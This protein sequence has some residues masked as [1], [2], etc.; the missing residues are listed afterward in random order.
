MNHSSHMPL[1]N[2][3]ELDLKRGDVYFLK[4]RVY[5]GDIASLKY[6]VS[7]L[8]PLLNAIMYGLNASYTETGISFN[9][10]LHAIPLNFM[11]TMNATYLEEGEWVKDL[12]VKRSDPVPIDASLI[13]SEAFIEC[14]E[15]ENVRAIRHRVDTSSHAVA[16]S[17]RTL[18]FRS[19]MWSIG[20][21][22]G[23][24]VSNEEVRAIVDALRGSN[25]NVA[26]VH[27]H[28][29]CTQF[30]QK[31]AVLT[32]TLKG[33]KV[34]IGGVMIDVTDMRLVTELDSAISKFYKNDGRV[35]TPFGVFGAIK[36]SN[37]AFAQS[38]WGV[39]CALLCGANIKVPKNPF[40]RYAMIAAWNKDYNDPISRWVRSFVSFE[41]PYLM[42]RKIYHAS[43]ADSLPDMRYCVFIDEE[44]VPTV[45]NHSAA[46]VV[47]GYGPALTK[48]SRVSRSKGRSSKKAETQATL[49]YKASTRSESK[50]VPKESVAPKVKFERRSGK[51]KGKS[52][53]KALAEAQ[54][55][56]DAAK[57]E[58][59]PE[60]V[61]VQA[62]KQKEWADI[63]MDAPYEEHFP[64]PGT[65]VKV[66][67]K[68][69]SSSSSEDDDSS[70]HEADVADVSHESDELP[71]D[72]VEIHERRVET[73]SE[74]LTRLLSP[75]KV[76]L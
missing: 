23:S 31:H 5:Q 48:V 58:P 47:R 9:P 39:Y 3:V 74:T 26:S 36:S 60:I 18:G 75:A 27:F 76:N 17:Y 72:T 66:D 22:D 32:L 11:A 63:P 10:E 7:D 61:P 25:P 62:P 28:S 59:E 29:D 73:E 50:V 70:I 8:H 43:D 6:A 16:P 37:G 14:A 55:M 49:R 15:M 13:P 24:D 57:A 4:D 35:R 46:D 69:R 41:K 52:K 53:S 20:T 33:Y 12:V 40:K 1:S 67:E 21:L 68:A 65:V 64:E 34:C 56:W 38:M 45:R 42:T 19:E 71:T 2:F 30:V 54:D 44:I 51:G